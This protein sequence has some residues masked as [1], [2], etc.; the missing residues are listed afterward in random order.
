MAAGFDVIYLWETAARSAS[1][2]L[3]RRCVRFVDK[4]MK[5]RFLPSK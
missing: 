3:P 1:G 5:L 4:T 2:Q